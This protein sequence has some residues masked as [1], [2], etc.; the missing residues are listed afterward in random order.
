MPCILKTKRRSQSRNV[1]YCNKVVF[2]QAE[3]FHT[4]TAAKNSGGKVCQSC[5]KQW[6]I[7]RPIKV[8]SAN[9]RKRPKKKRRAFEG[10]QLIAKPCPER[11][12]CYSIDIDEQRL[13]ITTVF[14]LR[15]IALYIANN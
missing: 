1:T 13:D 14:K 3:H 7:E 9:A 10:K 5:L 15:T 6:K 4:I 11:I 12:E 8:S 2:E